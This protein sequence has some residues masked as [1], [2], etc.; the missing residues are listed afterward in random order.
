MYYKKMCDARF[1]NYRYHETDTR[2]L[3]LCSIVV[4][5]CQKFSS[6]ASTLKRTKIN[7]E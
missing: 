5:C 7:Y 2:R 1:G 6:N 4:K 3:A